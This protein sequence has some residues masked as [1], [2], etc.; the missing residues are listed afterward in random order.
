MFVQLL[1]LFL[2]LL[3]CFTGKIP[4]GREKN[5]EED[6]QI[7]PENHIQ[8]TNLPED[9]LLSIV[10]QISPL[11][12]S[13]FLYSIDRSSDFYSRL[14]TSDE[15]S[16]ILQERL[17]KEAFRKGLN[18]GLL[19]ILNICEN[20]LSNF[21]NLNL[22]AE[23]LQTENIEIP[24]V[25][26]KTE[27]LQTKFEGK[28]VHFRKAQKIAVV[29]LAKLVLKDDGVECLCDMLPRAILDFSNLEEND[30]Q[31]LEKICCACNEVMMRIF[32]EYFNFVM[33]LFE[34]IFR[35]NGVGIQ[36]GGSIINNLQ[37][38]TLDFFTELC[39]KLEEEF[40]EQSENG[41]DARRKL[42]ICQKLRVILEERA[43]EIENR[44]AEELLQL[45]LERLD[46]IDRES[47]EF[48]ELNTKF[49]SCFIKLHDMI[50]S[51]KEAADTSTN[52]E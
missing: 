5:F 17:S 36:N 42:V 16:E 33:D 20:Q 29:V 28:W 31:V 46:A 48:R 32:I 11:M 14:L 15:L 2:D 6:P 44:T 3:S 45:N 27:H 10:E 8:Q 38:E 7:T 30:A 49:K 4:F 23:V 52:D 19:K 25:I 13:T 22:N 50:K 24:P 21:E 51:M 1:F 37:K 26:F 39:H 12:T 9:Y 40:A 18:A 47:S 35:A 34:K 41:E 43:E